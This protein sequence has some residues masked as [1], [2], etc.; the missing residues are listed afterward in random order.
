LDATE[1]VQGC[2][3]IAV[4]SWLASKAAFR[5]HASQDTEYTDGFSD[6]NEA[7]GK[8]R[9]ATVNE[10]YIV[11]LVGM[12]FPTTATKELALNGFTDCGLYRYVFTVND[13]VSSIVTDRPE[14]IQL[15][16]QTAEGIEYFSLSS[17]HGA[18]AA[19]LN[20]FHSVFLWKALV[21]YLQSVLSVRGQ[22]KKETRCIC[23]VLT[24]TQH[25][26]SLNM[27]KILGVSGGKQIE[28]ALF[29]KTRAVAQRRQK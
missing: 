18:K 29:A 26:E 28:K 3:A 1:I 10:A 12:A 22:V 15:K 17:A 25:K 16:I 23:V 8:I 6:S 11:S 14:T 21:H 19:T 13:F 20:K 4:V 5:Y 7:E 9:E 2:H 24:G 27:A